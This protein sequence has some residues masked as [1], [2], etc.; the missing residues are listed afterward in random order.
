MTTGAMRSGD[1]GRLL[2]IDGVSKRFGGVLVLD[3]LDLTIS[4]GSIKSLIGPNG[5]G[6]TT[7]FNIIDGLEQV[8]SGR[9][10][11]DGRE[12]TMLAPEKIAAL[13]VGRT[14]Q[15]N[16]IFEHLNVVEN[17][18]VG[19]FLKTRV[20]FA[21]AGLWLP[22]T[23]REEHRNT[24]R[25]YEILEFLGLYEKARRKVSQVSAM[26]RKLIEMGRAMAM[27][28][29]LLLLDEPFAGL[30]AGEEAVMA[31]KI[32]RVRDQ[33]LA[34]LMI[35]HHFGILSDLCDEIAILHQGKIVAEGAPREIEN[36][37]KAIAAYFIAQGG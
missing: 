15:T 37:K 25:A 17:V 12:I 8:D 11:F 20:S 13:G 31:E 1:N 3:G 7:L 36:D 14:F 16:Q 21:G 2:A 4:R 18:L 23:Y 5:A 35:D 26:E 10:W 34:L 24:V 33:G 28:P 19:R 30:N 29:R 9:V 22:S 32:R 27:E 6:K